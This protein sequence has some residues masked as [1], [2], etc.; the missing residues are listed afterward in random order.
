MRMYVQ[1]EGVDRQ[2]RRLR[3]LDKELSDPTSFLKQAGVVLIDSSQKNIEA[4]G[5]PRWAPLSPVT[6]YLRARK[7]KGYREF[8]RGPNK[9]RVTEAAFNT[10]IAGISPLRDTGLLMASIGN[11]SRGGVYRL[12]RGA[13]TIGTKV[14]YA[15]P[16]HDGATTAGMIKGKKIPPRPFMFLSA[17]DKRRIHGLAVTFVNN[18]IARSKKG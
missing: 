7:R 15:A 2:F 6:V 12:E 11:S 4:G 17:A 18:A 14:K 13:I 10:E 9:G 3:G 5:R 16:L 8:K 1:I